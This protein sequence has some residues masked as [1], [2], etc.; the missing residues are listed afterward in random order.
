MKTQ[1]N[2][3]YIWLGKCNT[4]KPPLVFL[5]GFGFNPEWS[6]PMLEAIASERTV[7]APYLYNI[8]YLDKQPSSLAEYTDKTRGFLNYI[9]IHTYHLA[10]HSYGGTVALFLAAQD[11]R[12]A[13]VTACNP[14]LPVTYGVPSF[15][16]KKLRMSFDELRG[17]YGET[18]VQ[19]AAD[20][21][22][23][24]WFNA[25]KKLPNTLKTAHEIGSLSYDATHITAPTQI[26][27]GEHDDYFDLAA[28]RES[29]EK[30]C[31]NVQIETLPEMNHDWPLLDQGL[32]AQYITKMCVANDAR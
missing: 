14:M 18:G 24:Y 3:R 11:E 31:E 5:H 10:G 21:T 30:L 17:K 28:H 8:N 23:P 9:E 1:R 2:V 16:A 25:M 19:F 26:V 15:I 27:W 13:S 20:T 7:I 22:I 6:M 4:T 12:V 32:A 29:L